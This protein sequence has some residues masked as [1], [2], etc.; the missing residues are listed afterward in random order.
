MAGHLAPSGSQEKLCG[1][2][3]HIFSTHIVTKEPCLAS[4]QYCDIL[5]DWKVTQGG[6]ISESPACDHVHTTCGRAK[7]MLKGEH[8]SNSWSRHPASP[9][10]GLPSEQPWEEDPPQTAALRH[11][12]AFRVS[13]DPWD[14]MLHLSFQGTPNTT[15]QRDSLSCWAPGGAF[16]S[17]TCQCHAGSIR[18]LSDSSQ[19]SALGEEETASWE[20]GGSWACTGFQGGPGQSH[21]AGRAPP[22][23]GCLVAGMHLLFDSLLIFLRD[24]WL[25]PM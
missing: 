19:G 11:R 5:T 14:T 7:D 4:Y 16:D 22:L 25:H 17:L 3:A 21:R 20:D 18:R 6:I 9:P 12:A 10:G 1:D 8:L 23:L 2:S 13:E 24:A 15:H